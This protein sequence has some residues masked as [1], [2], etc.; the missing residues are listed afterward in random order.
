MVKFAA[1]V[2][3]SLILV[4]EAATQ[5]WSGPLGPDRGHAADLTACRVC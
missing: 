2:G 3:A 4:G 5:E 1:L